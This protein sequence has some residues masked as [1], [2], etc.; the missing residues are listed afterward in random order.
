MAFEYLVYI[1]HLVDFI[2]IMDANRK[3]NKK[4]PC[5]ARS[6]KWYLYSMKFSPFEGK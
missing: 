4:H 6:L 2:W 5:L 1:K 3:G